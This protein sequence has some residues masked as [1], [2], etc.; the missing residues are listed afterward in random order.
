MFN[1]FKYQNDERAHKLQ[2]D[3]EKLEEQLKKKRNGQHFARTRGAAHDPLLSPRPP[4]L[5][6]RRCSGW[7]ETG[8]PPASAP[9]AYMLAP[10]TH[11]SEAG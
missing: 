6:P 5:R 2:E 7:Q 8:C 3:K 9:N 10:L 11:L 1:Y 4:L